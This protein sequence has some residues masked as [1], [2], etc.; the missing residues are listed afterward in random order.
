MMQRANL[1]LWQQANDLRAAAAC[2]VLLHALQG[3]LHCV[4]LP[5]LLLLLA[6]GSILLPPADFLVEPSTL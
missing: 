5:C 3:A 6:Q 1:E 4:Q 2:L